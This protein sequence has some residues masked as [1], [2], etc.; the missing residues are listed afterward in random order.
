MDKIGTFWIIKD[1]KTGRRSIW[2]EVTNIELITS[3]LLS[4]RNVLGGVTLSLPV[5]ITDA[6]D[7]AYKHAFEH[8]LAQPADYVG[9]GQFKSVVDKAMMDACMD[10]ELQ[11]G[12]YPVDS[13]KSADIPLLTEEDI[14]ADA[15]D[16]E[17]EDFAEGD[18]EDEE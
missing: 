12:E 11:K 9:E 3:P 1:T 15:A 5:D 2:N 14:L 10:F 17:F 4:L 18:Y 13:P 6:K 7:I 16:S 8:T